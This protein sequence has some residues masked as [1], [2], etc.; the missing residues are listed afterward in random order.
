MDSKEPSEV[1]QLLQHLG[2]GGQPVIDRLFAAVYQELRDLAEQFFRREQPGQTLQATALVNEAYLKLVDQRCVDWQGRA[3]FMGVA[4]Q[5]MRRILLDHAR[6][7]GAAKRGG[8]WKRITLN[9]RL[10]PGLKSDEELV[11]LDDALGKLSEVD[12]RQAHMV[13]LRFFGGLSVEEVAQV[14]GMSKR[15]VER[16]WTMVRAW[17]RREL[18]TS[19]G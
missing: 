3:H 2:V 4:A 11:A 14:L 17:L 12:P 19:S 5:A 1:T 7:R 13:E 16:E 9:D 18:S 10:I 8:G 6:K 15:S